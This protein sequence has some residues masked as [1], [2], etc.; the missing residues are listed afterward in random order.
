MP[1]TFGRN[2]KIGIAAEAS[3]LEAWAQ[4]TFGLYHSDLTFD[5]NIELASDVFASGQAQ[6]MLTEIAQ[7]R[8]DVR[9]TLRLRAW[10]EQVGTIFKHLLGTVSSSIISAGPFYKHEFTLNNASPVSF[11]IVMQFA[12][13]QYQIRGVQ[14]RRMTI[15]FTPGE[16][17]MIN[18]ECVGGDFVSAALGTAPT[19]QVTTGA[20]EAGFKFVKND[21]SI[22]SVL[23]WSNLEFVIENRLADS[24]DDSYSAA[25]LD[26]GQSNLV[27]TRLE[28]ASENDPPVSIMLTARKVRND[29]SLFTWFHDFTTFE[30]KYQSGTIGSGEYAFHIEMGVCKV[31]K[32]TPLV[33]GQSMG[34]DELLIES[35]YS[36]GTFYSSP[37]AD[38]RIRLQNKQVSI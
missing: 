4:P 38:F 22:N 16:W 14:I 10:R 29:N 6:R 8:K 5:L 21:W 37:S 30:S 36:Q 1:V 34:M 35:F 20:D 26:A 3:Y 31:R 17:V 11:R 23:G 28:R 27:R 9:F 12:D 33:R 32:H 15:P 7:G 24:P 2:V 18:L 13:V 25:A 19:Y